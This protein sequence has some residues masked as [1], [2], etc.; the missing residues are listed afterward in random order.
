MKFM[1]HDY[2]KYCGARQNERCQIT[3]IP[4]L[5]K[6]DKDERKGQFLRYC[7]PAGKDVKNNM[8]LPVMITSE[9]VYHNN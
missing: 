3:S 5:V 2:Q 8:C 9:I 1:P 4:H 6:G 7:G